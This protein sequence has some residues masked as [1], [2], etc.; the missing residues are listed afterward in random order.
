M[1]NLETLVNEAEALQIEEEQLAWYNKLTLE[2]RA[3]FLQLWD[4]DIF[5]FLEKL[6]LAKMGTSWYPL[7]ILVAPDETSVRVTIT[8]EY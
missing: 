7:P 1:R 2:E 3:L 4:K 8:R 6:W 5:T